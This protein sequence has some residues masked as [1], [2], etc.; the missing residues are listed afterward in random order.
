[1]S[2]IL[3]LFWIYFRMCIVNQATKFQIL[4]YFV[5]LCVIEI[6]K[7][8]TVSL[9]YRSFDMLVYAAN[10]FS[11]HLWFAIIINL[12]WRNLHLVSIKFTN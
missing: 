4:C 3:C 2:A 5:P 7:C 11:I 9:L 1:M 6:T 8:Y 10:L 12:T